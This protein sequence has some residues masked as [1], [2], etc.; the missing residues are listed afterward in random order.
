MDPIRP[1]PG[2]NGPT[3]TG[4][5][6]PV[7]ATRQ[8][9]DGRFEIDRKS[10]SEPVVAPSEILRPEG[11]DLRRIQAGIREAAKGVDDP[12]TVMGTVVRAEL[13]TQFGAAL[14]GPSLDQAVEL[15]LQDPGMRQLFN[16][17][18]GNVQSGGAE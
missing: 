10:A 6:R 5:V 7:N 12:A 14:D 13:E 17:L 16:R 4:D 15:L 11:A 2:G 18:L 1:V 9:S 3:P 8:E